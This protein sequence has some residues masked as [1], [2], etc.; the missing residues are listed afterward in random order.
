MVS[1]L[2]YPEHLHQLHSPTDTR[3]PQNDC[4]QLQKTKDV[5]INRKGTRDKRKRPHSTTRDI[6]MSSLS[7]GFTHISSHLREKKHLQITFLNS[8][9]WE[10]PFVSINNSWLLIVEWKN[11]NDKLISIT[12]LEKMLFEALD[13]CC[14]H[15]CLYKWINQTKCTHVPARCRGVELRPWV[16]LQ[17]IFSGVDSF[18]T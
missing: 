18:M 9:S 6:N 5:T 14:S 7:R 10:R 3:Q 8:Y 17:L 4:N 16:S 15:E 12:N 11:W 2:P 13:S 1:T